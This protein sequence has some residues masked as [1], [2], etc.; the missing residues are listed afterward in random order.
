MR[1]SLFRCFVELYEMIWRMET[2][3]HSIGFVFLTEFV[4]DWANY[5]GYLS[6]RFSLEKYTLHIKVRICTYFLYT[7]SNTHF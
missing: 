6:T 1:D 4:Y 5:I 3:E 7:L 2:D